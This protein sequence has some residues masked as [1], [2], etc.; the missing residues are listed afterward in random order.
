MKILAIESSAKSASVAITEDELVL[1][2][3]FLN[4]GLTHSR[5][6]MPMIES[7]IEMTGIKLSAIDRI[8]VAAGPGSFT[9]LRIG[10]SVAKGLSFAS[11]IPCCGV[12]TLGAMANNMVHAKG[13][14]CAVMDA[15]AGQVYNALFRVSKGKITRETQDRAIS[16]ADLLS[17]IIF[18]KDV[19]LL[20]DG[21][22][23]CYNEFNGKADGI[24][25]A[26]EPLLLQSAR[27]V[28]VSAL[29]EAALGAFDLSVKYILLP[30]AERERLKKLGKECS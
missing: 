22:K 30:Q 3:V 21:A 15:R 28:A 14:L 2:E 6:I 8:A 4:N 12:S 10:V 29:S 13:L 20:G 19:Y 11:G 17:E 7:L 18:E 16:S 26:P 5:T 9:G 1:A 23:L 25:L 24:M 27:G